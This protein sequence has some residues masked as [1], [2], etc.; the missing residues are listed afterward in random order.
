MSAQI[1]VSAYHSPTKGTG[2]FQRNGPAMARQRKSKRSLEHLLMPERKCFKANGWEGSGAGS[3]V[4][5]ARS[6]QQPGGAA[7]REAPC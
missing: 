4:G 7:G 3:L 1:W 2:A 5:T 6:S